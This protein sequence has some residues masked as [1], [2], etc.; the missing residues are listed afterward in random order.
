MS[1]KEGYKK[2]KKEKIYIKT[3]NICGIKINKMKI[4]VKIEYIYNGNI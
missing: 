3:R 4:N 2:M 1:I